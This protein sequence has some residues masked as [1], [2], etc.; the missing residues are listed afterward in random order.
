MS[1]PP[2]SLLDLHA[3]MIRFDTV[4]SHLSGRPAPEAGLAAALEAWAGDW[5]LQT[6]RF[7]VRDGQFNLL[8]GSATTFSED[9]LLLESHLDT[10][11]AEGMTIA[12]FE[13]VLR[14]GKIFG[15]GSCDTKASGAA[16]LWALKTAIANGPQPAALLFTVDEEIGKSG[17]RSF[18]RSDLPGFPQP[19]SL[20]V[21][22]EPTLLRPGVAHNGALRWKILTHGIPAHSSNPTNGRSAIRD[23]VRVIEA[24]EREY[25][26]KLDRT[27][28]LTGR[29]R[30]SI[31]LIQGGTQS[32]VIPDRC[33][34]V[35][36]RRLLPGETADDV[37]PLVE[38]ILENLRE[39]HAGLRVEQKDGKPDLGMLTLDRERVMAF[40]EPVL[41]SFGIDA[42]GLGLPYGTDASELA[43]AGIPSVVLGPGNIEQA[44]TADEWIARDQLETAAELYLA[45]LRAPSFPTTFAE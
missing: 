43:A 45:I 30:C 33:E 29:A 1:S 41:E 24:I 9:W 35:V 40:L 10:V 13:P 36:E 22:G 4:N 18:V 20:A 14:D 37:L 16:M 11:T 27:H 21:V 44:H 3:E 34:I 31:N 32:N 39:E 15:R 6:R 28:P 19:P 38:G 26:A 7:P 2:A 12:P 42:A 23:M 25:I 8:V 17:I 5:G